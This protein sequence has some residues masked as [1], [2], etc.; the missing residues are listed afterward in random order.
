MFSSK[1]IVV[2]G[3]AL[4]IVAANVPGAPRVLTGDDLKDAENTLNSSLQKLASGDGP[5]YQLG[6]IIS[7]TRQVVSGSLYKYEVE[8]V[9]GNKATK[10]CNVSIWSQPWLDNGIEVSF[11][12][13][14]ED[15]VVKKHS[16]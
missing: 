9:D 1:V 3:L 5:N 6:K 15:K 10:K 2:L 13:P 14:G 8:L 4:T 11:E 16:A 7:A 12:C